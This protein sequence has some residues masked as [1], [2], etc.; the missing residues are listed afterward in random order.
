M[1]DGPEAGLKLMDDLDLGEHL[2]G[3]HLYHAARADLLRRS[4]KPALAAEAYEAALRLVANAPER[5]Y[6]QRRLQE[7]N[8]LA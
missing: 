3:Y 8:A 5:R 4:G 6:L 7:M 1:A 2:D